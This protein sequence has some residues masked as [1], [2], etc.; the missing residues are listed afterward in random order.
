MGY[1]ASCPFLFLFCPAQAPGSWA[2]AILPLR[3]QA[4][5]LGGLGEGSVSTSHHFTVNTHTHM[6]A[7]LWML[8]ALLAAV[9]YPQ[10]SYYWVLCLPF[11]LPGTPLCVFLT[12]QLLSLHVPL[13]G[14][15][16]LLVL[17]LS[18]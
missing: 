16:F 8:P 4:E 14:K 3:M 2:D 1:I 11:H 5:S 9:T 7:Y 18:P 17:L 13:S 15:P 10:H 12:L 6:R